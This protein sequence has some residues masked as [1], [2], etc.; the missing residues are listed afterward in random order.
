MSLNSRE[1]GHIGRL[2][3]DYIGAAPSER[4]MRC[5]SQRC[6][7]PFGKPDAVRLL[8]FESDRFGHELAPGRPRRD[9]SSL[10]SVPTPAF[11]RLPDALRITSLSRPALYRRTA[12][13]RF[14]RPVRLV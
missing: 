13:C 4:A 11:Y 2:V 5:H 3:I 1:S 7:A 9:V 10:A 8:S 14:P 6:S 12:T